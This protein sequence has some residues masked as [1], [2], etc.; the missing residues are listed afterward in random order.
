MT[1]EVM[2][3]AF[4]FFSFSLKKKQQQQKKRVIAGYEIACR[5]RHPGQ[6]DNCIFL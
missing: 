1:R 3:Q 6:H 4:L 2:Y 5:C